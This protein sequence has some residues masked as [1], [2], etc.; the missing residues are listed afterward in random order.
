MALQDFGHQAEDFLLLAVQHIGIRV[1][2]RSLVN[3]NPG[4]PYALARASEREDWD[5]GTDFWLFIQTVGWVRLD[6]TTARRPEIL[7]K[8]RA[9]TDVCTLCV[10]YRTLEQASRGCLKDLTVLYTIFE[11][12]VKEFVQ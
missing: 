6:L 7:A 3:T 1:V 4:C 5:E 11:S 2:S 12:L 8:K 9:R 10:N